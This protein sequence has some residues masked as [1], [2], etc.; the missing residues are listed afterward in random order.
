M[1]IRDRFLVALVLLM[2]DYRRHYRQLEY[3]AFMDPVTGIGNN[4]AF[5]F[6]CRALLRGAPPSSYCMVL[7]NLVN[8]KLINQGFGIEAGDRTLRYI[9]RM[10]EGSI[11]TGEAAARADS[12]NFF[13]C[14]QNSDPAQIQQRLRGILE[15]INSFDREAWGSYQLSFR[16]GIYIIDDPAMEITIMQDRAKTAYKNAGSEA[17]SY[18][19]LDV[20]KRQRS[21]RGPGYP[22]SGR[23]PHH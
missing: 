8:F 18:T 5:Q 22:G 13:L 20:Y 4:A 11:E 3:A 2:W 14:M 6:Q 9:A 12:D 1:C 15:K 17:V 10:L 21:Y 19:H 16:S 23:I 7:L